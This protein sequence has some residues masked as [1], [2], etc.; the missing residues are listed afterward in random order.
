LELDTLDANYNYTVKSGGSLPAYSFTS[1]YD[2]AANKAVMT[3]MNFRLPGT[4]NPSWTVTIDAENDAYDYTYSFRMGMTKPNIFN[5]VNTQQTIESIVMVSWNV[6]PDV[7]ISNISPK[8]SHISA[9][10]GLG[11]SWTNKTVTSVITDNYNC[12][13]YPGIQKDGTLGMKVATYPSATLKLLNRGEATSATMTFANAK[14]Y[15]STSPS[16][17]NYISYYEWG[18]GAE[19]TRYL[20]YYSGGRW[21]GTSTPTGTVSSNTVTLTY[22]DVTF[23]FTLAN[24]VT[25]N[26]IKAS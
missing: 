24:T 5:Y 17:G 6:M 10:S 22:G 19:A 21:S 1:T 16:S 14:F 8:G 23:T 12:T 7:I 26:N 18:T 25:I 13:V 4:Y 2:E 3:S 15:T 11:L 20:G 9:T